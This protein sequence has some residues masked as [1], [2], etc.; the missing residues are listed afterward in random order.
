MPRRAPKAVRIV[1]EPGSAE[2]VAPN[3]GRV[4]SSRRIVLCALAVVAGVTAVA[5]PAHAESYVVRPGDTLSGVARQ[6]GMSSAELQ[7]ANDLRDPNRLIAGRTLVIP[8]LV[9]VVQ[10]GEALSVVAR[11][12]GTTTAALVRANGLTNPDHVRAGQTLRIRAATSSPSVASGAATAAPP[13][14][15]P[16]PAAPAAAPPAA[17]VAYTV[18]PGEALSVL[19]RRLGTTTGQLLR[20][21]DLSHPDLIRAGEVLHIPA[22][23]AP[24]ASETTASVAKR[25]PGLPPRLRALPERMALIPSFERWAAAYGLPVELLMAVAWRESGWQNSAVS[26][27]GALGIGQLMPTT[28]AWVATRIAGVPSLHPAV[29][30]DNIRMSAAYLSWLHGQMG[31]RDLAIASYFQ[32]PNSVRL[33]GVLPVSEAYL[34][35]VA[36]LLATFRP[37]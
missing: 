18:R 22:G 21:N 32:G 15:A 35:G 20:L 2:R 6:H 4:G 10:P 26:S 23:L 17:T 16:R 5:G 30:D 33:I 7:A 31:G 12:Y 14:R 8:P 27:K 28:A 1:A 19:A 9:H 34:A 37:A 11:R 3:A 36:S 24:P 29:P 13:R 25:Y